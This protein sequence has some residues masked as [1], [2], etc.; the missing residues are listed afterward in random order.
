MQHYHISI[1]KINYAQKTIF[2]KT[3]IDFNLQQAA[4]SLSLDLLGMSI[5][6]IY[7]QNFKRYAYDGR[8]LKIYFSQ[9]ILSGNIQ[10]QYHGKPQQDATWGGFY[11]SGVYAFNLGVGFTSEPHNLGRVWFP[12]NDNFSD[13]ATYTFAIQVPEN[14]KA[15]CNGILDSTD[16]NI[17]YWNMKV[18][19][20]TYLASMAVAPYEIVQWEHKGIPFTLAS[21]PADTAKMR[22]SFKQLNLAFDVFESSYGPHFFPRV[23]YNAVPFS[24]GAMEHASNI[25]YPL[26]TITGFEENKTLYAHELAHHWFGNA[27]TCA[28]ASQMWLNEGWATY[29]E[30]LFVEKADGKEAYRQEVSNVHKSILHYAHLKDEGYYPVNGVDHDRTYGMHVYQKGAD[31]IHTLRGYMGDSAFFKACQSYMTKFKGKNA[32]T[33][34]LKSEFQKFTTRNLDLF[35]KY[36]INAPGSTAFNIFSW[37]AQPVGDGTYNLNIRIKQNLRHAPELFREVPMEIY[38][39]DERRVFEVH[40]LILS[41][42]DSVYSLKVDRQPT[43]LA[44]DFAEKISDAITDDK[45]ITADTL[46]QILPS[47]LFSCDILKNPDST[48]LRVEHFWTSPDHYYLKKSIF[49]LSSRRYWKV[50]GIWKQDFKARGYFEFNA[51]KP[52]SSYYNGYL[53]DD[54]D[55]LNEDSIVLMY[56]MNPESEWELA[57][58]VKKL[59]GTNL[60]KKATYTVEPL[61]KG[62]YAFAKTGVPVG[63]PNLESNLGLVVFPNPSDHWVY[64][65]F[66]SER[67]PYLLEITDL[68]GRISHRARLNQGESEYIYKE[69]LVPGVYWISVYTPIGLSQSTKL[70]VK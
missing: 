6:T 24:S 38:V 32:T 39:F 61:L 29:S 5:D 4:D 20:P 7:G 67:E 27:V 14:Y 64:I 53:D 11:F 56:R 63:I 21:L 3:S 45:F 16:G 1:E 40:E 10:I 42:L 52:G 30:H 58:G 41:G 66:D 69:K 9:A 44:L 70:I 37:S 55:V 62:E 35:F 43:F 33:D 22:G 18:P 60:D 47:A 2:G 65:R 48:L 25:A 68:Q 13:R 26:N 50:D 59:T 54:L 28:D 46:S 23:G 19:I 57:P 17:W 15:M 34:D 31:M 51:R 36:W 8:Y 12:C 49:L